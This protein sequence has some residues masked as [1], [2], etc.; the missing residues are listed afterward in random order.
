MI[1]MMPKRGAICPLLAFSVNQPKCIFIPK[2]AAI[3]LGPMRRAL[4]RVSRFIVSFVLRAIS[5]SFVS[6]RSFVIP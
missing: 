6:L 1:H 5:V 2:N 4:K 3:V